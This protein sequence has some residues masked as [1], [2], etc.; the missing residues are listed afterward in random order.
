MALRRAVAAEPAIEIRAG[1]RVSGLLAD[2]HN[3]A[4]RV[5]GVMLDGAEPVRGDIVVDA[6]GRYRAPPGWARAPVSRPSAAR[7]TT[8]VTSSCARASTTSDAPILNPRGD[9]GYMGFNTFR[10][11]NRTYAVILLVPAADRGLRILREESAFRPRAPR[12]PRLMPCAHLTTDGRS[13]TSCR[14]AA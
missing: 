6:L 7:S 2:D 12:S 9:L 1:L 8:A 5:D 4:R 13:P 14:W 10:G 3:G 11:D